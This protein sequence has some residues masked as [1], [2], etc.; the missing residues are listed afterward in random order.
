MIVQPGKPKKTTAA[1]AKGK[2][3]AALKRPA[4]SKSASLPQ[5]DE[6]SLPSVSEAEAAAADDTGSDI[7]ALPSDPEPAFEAGSPKPATGASAAAGAPPHAVITPGEVEPKSK[8]RK[9][10]SEAKPKKEPKKQ[11]KKSPGWLPLPA[12]AKEKMAAL[13]H[14]KC[15]S[16]GCPEC[17]RRIGLVLNADETAWVYSN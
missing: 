12:D 1:K 10:G 15:R 17:R 5:T 3:K 14:S 11:N 8:K 13:K 6:V 4:A 2:A 7:V 16:R 9:T